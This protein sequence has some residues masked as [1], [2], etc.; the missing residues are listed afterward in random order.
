MQAVAILGA[1]G[2]VGKSTVAVNLAAALAR[3]GQRVVLVDAD[4]QGG[5]S[6]HLG[7][8]VPPDDEAPMTT[9]VAAGK[10]PH[11]LVA[12]TRFYGMGLIAA[13]KSLAGFDNLTFAPPEELAA[14]MRS[15][16]KLGDV[17]DWV[18]ID[19]P[20]GTGK[21]PFM[22]CA[23][24]DLAIV[25]TTYD[26]L[27]V[28]PL[29]DTVDTVVPTAQLYNPSLRVLGIIGSKFDLRTSVNRSYRNVIFDTLYP[30]M[31]LAEL[32]ERT[33]VKEAQQAHVPLATYLER[34]MKDPAREVVEQLDQ[35]AVRMAGLQAE[36]V[37]HG[38]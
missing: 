1:K 32:P 8:V 33:R 20:P 21:L 9:L 22:A 30:G 3:R 11:E 12:P 19:T 2:G 15:L 24:A 7:V 5:A 28:L 25:V 38:E 34:R 31:V 10:D 37:V 6:L 17:A 4:P 29:R 13:N 14:M 35:L 26:D 36:V 16:R 18:I 27:G 23:A